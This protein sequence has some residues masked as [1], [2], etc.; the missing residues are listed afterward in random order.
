MRPEG[1]ERLLRKGQHPN[2]VRV[3]LS[4][5][6]HALARQVLAHRDLSV[7]EVHVLAVES[8][9]FSDAHPATGQGP[10][11]G[12]LLVVGCSVVEDAEVPPGPLRPGLALDGAHALGKAGVE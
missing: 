3:R 6:N 2:L 11:D 8:E 9:G 7:D 10:K 4:A 1:L 12:A 5:G